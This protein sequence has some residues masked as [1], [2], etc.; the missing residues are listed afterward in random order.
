[1]TRW[2]NLRVP[3]PAAALMLTVC[4]VWACA[5]PVQAEVRLHAS[6]S[7]VFTLSFNV[8]RRPAADVLRSADQYQPEEVA[9]G[10][11][12]LIENILQPQLA[13]LSQL[14]P[15]VSLLR[16]LSADKANRHE[17]SGPAT[18]PLNALSW[19]FPEHS[20]SLVSPEYPTLSQIAPGLHRLTLDYAATAL[21][22]NLAGWDITP[23][24]SAD[25]AFDNAEYAL[26]LSRQLADSL[27]P[28]SAFSSRLTPL[29]SSAKTIDALP[30]SEVSTAAAF[31]GQAAAELLQPTQE[32]E[33]VRRWMMPP[34][35]AAEFRGN[36]GR[37]LVNRSQTNENTQPKLIRAVNSTN[38]A[39]RKS[40][41]K[42]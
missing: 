2:I 12:Q 21:G 33:A 18:L 15:P 3:V 25:S 19:S 4:G 22:G 39:N 32:G 31:Q 7:T 11:L 27:P 16:S 26:S 38:S 23:G 1:M 20:L 42:R 30:L 28:S 14:L 13:K 40:E 10:S 34:N 9:A 41:F 17:Y 37:T 6:T 35:V 29:A 24:L 36:S 8:P 5:V